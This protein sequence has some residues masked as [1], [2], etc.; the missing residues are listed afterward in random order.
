MVN[1]SCKLELNKFII[2]TV[3]FVQLLVISVICNVSANMLLKFGVTKGGG[4]TLQKTTIVTDVLRAA[5]NPF[6]ILGLCLYGISFV[7]W[8][9]VLSFN[10]LSK[11]YP[12]FVTF[13]FIVT[14]IGTAIFFKEHVS[15]LRI[16]GMAVSIIGIY[17]IARS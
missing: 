7:L 16:L 12:I 13:V 8:L 6:I 4:F 3:S 11:T 10:D 17:L 1:E 2:L 5:Q 14:T 15:L 9:R